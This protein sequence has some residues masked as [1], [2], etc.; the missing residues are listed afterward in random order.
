MWTRPA[1]KQRV[2]GRHAQVAVL[3]L[4]S[5]GAQT[6]DA[7]SPEFLLSISNLAA[8]LMIPTTPPHFKIRCSVDHEHNFP[9][10]A[11]LSL[12]AGTRSFHSSL[13]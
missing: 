12:I 6:A 3:E 10:R 13:N 2:R 1:V 11:L 5:L 9:G 8:E 7:G 4:P